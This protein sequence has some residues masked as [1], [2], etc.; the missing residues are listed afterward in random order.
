M[1]MLMLITVMMSINFLLVSHPLSMGF[2]LLMQTII[3]SLMCGFNLSSYFMSYIL[4]L[5]FIGGMMIL[6]MYMSSIASNEKFIFSMKLTLMN[7]LMMIIISFININFN[8]QNM[9]MSINFH[10]EYC[11][12]YMNKLYS[13]PSGNI[14]L[15]M[16]IYLLFTLIIVSN[17]IKLKMAPFRSN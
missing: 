11:N 13:L 3:A 15:L 8:S 9:S 17:I 10:N 5:I 16:I 1:K 4:F 6:F 2:I 14:T 7:I 12:Y